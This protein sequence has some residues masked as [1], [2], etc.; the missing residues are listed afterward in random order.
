MFV[1]THRVIIRIDDPISTQELSQMPYLLGRLA[2]ESLLFPLHDLFSFFFLLLFLF[3]DNLSIYEGIIL[4]RFRSIYDMF[5]L[6]RHIYVVVSF[7]FFQSF[8]L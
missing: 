3:L 7:F 1:S 2:R 5:S 8:C 4:S 6:P